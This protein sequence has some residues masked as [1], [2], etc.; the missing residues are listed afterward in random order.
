[1][2][3]NALPLTQIASPARSDD[4]VD[5]EI[6]KL[7]QEM[8]QAQKEEEKEQAEEKEDEDD[9]NESIER[10]EKNP[11]KIY[12]E[13]KAE[14]MLDSCL[15]FLDSSTDH[16]MLEDNKSEN[17]EKTP[18]IQEKPKKNERNEENSPK[19]TKNLAENSPETTREKSKRRAARQ[20]ENDDDEYESEEEDDEA[21]NPAAEYVANFDPEVFDV[22][23][24]SGNPLYEFPVPPAGKY[25]THEEIHAALRD[26]ALRH[27]YAIATR[28][29]VPGKSRTWKCD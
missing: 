21:E 23:P 14:I 18:K 29:S 3:Q 4:A 6:L 8:I 11:D 17:V 22:D 26:F 13:L 28:R 7:T 9:D 2:S 19:K 1:M 16:C 25:T 27:G 20:F 12:N 10:P 24:D 15:S 5:P